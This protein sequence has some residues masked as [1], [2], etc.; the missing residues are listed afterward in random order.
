[1]TGA[2]ALLV[3]GLVLWAGHRMLTSPGSRSTGMRDGLG[4]FIDVFDPAQ[5]RADRDVQSDKNRKA[6]APSPDPDDPTRIV[7]DLT[8]NRA[9]VPRPPESPSEG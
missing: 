9:R 6:V 7:V 1:M 5:S 3:V 4:N 2:V 8:I